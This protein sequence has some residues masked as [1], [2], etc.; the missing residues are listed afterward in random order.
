MR[1][2]IFLLALAVTALGWVDEN[3]RDSSIPEGTLP[4]GGDAITLTIL[5]TFQVSSAGQMLGLDTQDGSSQLVV[6]DS[7]AGLIR[8][9]VMGTGNPVWT[10]PT[11]VS[12]TFGCCHNWPVTY[13]WYVNRFLG[14]DMYYYFDGI[15]N[16]VF[17]NPTGQH[18]R[19]MDFQNDGNYIWET[20]SA[21]STH[22]IYRIDESGGYTSYT[23]SE[24]PG[25]M[26]GL[27]VFP[28]NGNL[29]IF[30]TCYDFQEWFL[31]EFDGSNLTYKGS[32]SPGLSN[33]S[34]SLGLTYHPDTDTFFW[35]YKVYGTIR[36]IAEIQFT[37]TALEQSTWG[38]IKTQF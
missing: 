27:A 5:N 38:S 15:W 17:A 24:V 36:W 9:V 28:Y 10:I 18:G 13:G 20:Y 26:S 33:F 22:Q 23:V 12:Y 16:V 1:Y 4:E 32:G 8:G 14:T 31:F 35:S 25:Q 6:M 3:G 11:P 7:N 2:L 30:V 37:E 21:A 29:G 34:L 19:G